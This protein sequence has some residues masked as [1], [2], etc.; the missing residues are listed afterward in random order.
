M[1]PGAESGPYGGKGFC[2]LPDGTSRAHP[3]HPDVQHVHS[4]RP[5][6]WRGRWLLGQW[7]VS[8]FLKG[9]FLT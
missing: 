1:S 5:S 8:P 9:C 2:G 3:S 4:A 7:V 6:G